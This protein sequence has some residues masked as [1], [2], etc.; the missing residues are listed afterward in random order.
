MTTGTDLY[1]RV[2]EFDYRDEERRDLVQKTWSAT[3]WM[4]NAHTGG[5][6]DDP[7]RENEIHSW[8]SEHF[9]QEHDPWSGPPGKWRRG[10]ATICGWT[11]MG[12][13]TDDMMRQFI[14]RWPPMADSPLE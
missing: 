3:P 13:A 12:F 14:E 7:V 8:C 4:V 5:S 9:G 10:L 1:R 6:L 2:I 11:W